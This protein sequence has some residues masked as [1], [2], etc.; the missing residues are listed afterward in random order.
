VSLSRPG[1]LGKSLRPL[2][3][4]REAGFGPVETR[5][6]F[7]AMLARI[8]GNG[9]RTIIVETANRFARDLMVQE[10]GFAMLRE[11]GI[12]LIAADSPA[13][14]LDDGPTSKDLVLQSQRGCRDACFGL[15]EHHVGLPHHSASFLVGGDDAGRP[16][17]R[18]YNEIAPESGTAVGALFLLLGFH[19]PNDPAGGSRGPVDLVE[20]APRIR[21]VEEAV[22]GECGGLVVFIAARTAKRNR[23]S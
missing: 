14:F 22:F 18:R 16:V 10:V 17:G 1:L 11:F 15:T 12:R 13:S 23:I 6:G 8:A 9:V 7:A 19:A 2:F 4:A 20:H 5:P 3:A 21:D